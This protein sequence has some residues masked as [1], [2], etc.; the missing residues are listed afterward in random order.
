MLIPQVGRQVYL[1]GAGRVSGTSREHLPFW[2]S[3]SLAGIM[4]QELSHLCQRGDA[5]NL[6]SILLSVLPSY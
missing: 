1:G 4:G 6:G 2:R 3:E 5:A